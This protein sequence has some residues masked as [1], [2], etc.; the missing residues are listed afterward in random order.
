MTVY[1]C[2]RCGG[3]E[4]G[5]QRCEACNLWMRAVGIGNNCPSCGD[6]VSINELM[7]RD[8]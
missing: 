4:L 2:E 7:G 3:R 6:V 8:G 5:V 1:E